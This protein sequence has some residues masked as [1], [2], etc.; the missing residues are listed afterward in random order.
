MDG[1]VAGFVKNV[2]KSA[3]ALDVAGTILDNKCINKGIS[4]NLMSKSYE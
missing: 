1:L 4:I 2:F 3:Y